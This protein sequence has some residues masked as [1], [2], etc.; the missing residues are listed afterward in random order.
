MKKWIIIIL[1]YSIFFT[2]F[3][4]AQ[5][6]INVTQN[7]NSIIINFNLPNYSI[8]D[9]SVFDIYGISELYKYIKIENFG[10]IDIIG[11]PQLPQ[12]S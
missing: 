9:T 10:I 7:S 11:L 1:S 4:F 3:C 5:N 6:S 8:I 12:L 2:N